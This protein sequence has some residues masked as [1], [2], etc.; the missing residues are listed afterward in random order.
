ML[1]RGLLSASPSIMVFEMCVGFCAHLFFLRQ[2]LAFCAKYLDNAAGIWYN[3][4]ID[5][6]LFSRIEKNGE[7]IQT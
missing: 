2:K 5:I 4:R 7:V 6:L 1:L 3:E